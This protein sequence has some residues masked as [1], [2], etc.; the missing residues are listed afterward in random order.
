LH[1]SFGICFSIVK[2]KLKSF[3][4]LFPCFGTAYL[5]HTVQK[6][7]ERRY[8]L[9][10]NSTKLRKNLRFQKYNWNFRF[11]MNSGNF[12]FFQK[13]FIPKFRKMIRNSCK[14]PEILWFKDY[15]GIANSKNFNFVICCVVFH[16]QKVLG[17]NF[18]TICVS[19]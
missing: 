12:S 8:V 16:G 5:K 6:T 11:L 4:V 15:F 9:R 2:K 19:G 17:S 18:F 1:R 14:F 7:T 13:V 10:H 3:D